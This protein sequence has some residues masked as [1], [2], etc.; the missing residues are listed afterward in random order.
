MPSRTASKAS[1]HLQHRAERLTTEL[2]DLA[3]RHF[4]AERPLRSARNQRRTGAHHGPRRLPDPLQCTPVGTPPPSVSLPNGPSRNGAPGGLQPVRSPDPSPWARMARDHGALRRS[5][6][7]LPQLSR[8]RLTDPTPA[9][10]RLLLCLPHPPAHQHQAQPHQIRT[11]LSMQAVRPTPRTQPGMNI[12]IELT[13]SF[14][15]GSAGIQGHGRQQQESPEPFT[16]NYVSAVMII[17]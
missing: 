2:R 11:D 8:R 13:A 12:T 16:Q 7:T 4:D 6:R 10:V 17:R 5:A 1:D 3:A 15:Q 9:P 14:R